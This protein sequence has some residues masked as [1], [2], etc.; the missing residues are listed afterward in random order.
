MY[1]AICNR[2]QQAAILFL[3]VKSTGRANCGV[4]GQNRT[5]GID[6][7]VFKM[8]RSESY[9]FKN[10]ITHHSSAAVVSEIVIRLQKTGVL[11]YGGNYYWSASVTFFSSIEKNQVQSRVMLSFRWIGA[12]RGE[13]RKEYQ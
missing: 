12:C 3:P 6:G 11:N 5:V 9:L 10:I 1:Y 13:S 7:H 2:Y 4:Q 8:E